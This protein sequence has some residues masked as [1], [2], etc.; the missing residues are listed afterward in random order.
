MVSSKVRTANGAETMAILTGMVATDYE[1]LAAARSTEEKAFVVVGIDFAPKARHAKGFGGKRGGKKG[2]SVIGTRPMPLPGDLPAKGTFNPEQFLK[3]L[4]LC[5]ITPKIDAETGEVQRFP[6]GKVITFR[7]PKAQ[8]RDEQAL[9]AGFIG[10]DAGGMKLVND[11][12]V[13]TLAPL[14]ATQVDNARRV[15]QIHAK[16]FGTECLKPYRRTKAWAGLSGYVK[17]MPDALRA[18][19]QDFVSRKE[20]AVD[21][22]IFAEGQRIAHLDASEDASLTSQERAYHKREAATFAAKVVLESA[23]IVELD[24]ALVGEGFQKSE[25]CLNPTD[26]LAD[27]CEDDAADMPEDTS[28]ASP[29]VVAEELCGVSIQETINA[30]VEAD[31]SALRAA[32]VAKNAEEQRAAIAAKSDQHAAALASLDVEINKSTPKPEVKVTIVPAGVSGKS[33][34]VDGAPRRRIV[35]SKAPAQKSLA[36]QIEALKAANAALAAN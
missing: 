13:A 25:D 29:P 12:M 20:M 30:V 26:I 23:R 27:E 4:S 2:E 9:V 10:W 28:V 21:T 6:N 3:G 34:M 7:C 15:A 8:L 31:R 16:G 19:I 17:G 22:M 33:T 36:E 1:Q 18:R 5:G 11:Q 35:G 24:A 32:E 14:H